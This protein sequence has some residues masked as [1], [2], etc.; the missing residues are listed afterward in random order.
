MGVGIAFFENDCY[1]PFREEAITITGL[2][3]SNMAEYHAIINALRI[4]LKDYDLPSNHTIRIYTDS[5]LI[6]NQIIGDWTCINKQLRELNKEVLRLVKE[7]N[8]P[9]PLF[10]WVPREDERQRIVD[11]LSKQSNPYFQEKCVH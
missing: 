4:I 1:I 10:N 5:Q 11:R 7:I 9:L 6:C 2:G 8:Y 3:T